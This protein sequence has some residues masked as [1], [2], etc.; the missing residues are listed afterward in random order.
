MKDLPE[1]ER[2]QEKME[3][4]GVS[5]LDDTELL[6]LIM[7][8]GTRNANV[9]G[10][11]SEIM[12]EAISWHN[13][14]RWHQEDFMRIKGIGRAKANQLLVVMEI[15][16]RIMK[17]EY[18]LAPTFDSPESVFNH[19]KSVVLGLEVEKFWALYFDTK[20]RLLRRKEISSGTVSSS[21]V[22]PREFFKE[23]VRL[24][25]TSVIAVHNHPSGNPSPSNADIDTTRRLNEAARILGVDLLDHIIIGSLN[26][27]PS[28][29]GYYSFRENGMISQW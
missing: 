5:T 16:R 14:V 28:G 8:S 12:K 26:N 2:P 29:R 18:A 23:G 27:D 1:N 7:R 10:I 17:Q 11:A 25:A 4:E 6:A 3:S 20:N 24:S 21:I 15:A 13:L 19:F 9:L 22:H